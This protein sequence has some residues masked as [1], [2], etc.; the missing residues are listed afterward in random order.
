MSMAENVSI[1]IDFRDADRDD[2]LLERQTQTLF[3]ELQRLDE[4]AA[5]ERVADPNPP[6][7]NFSGGSWLP[8]KLVVQ[9][10]VQG[11]A[12]AMGVIS[13]QLGGRAIVIETKGPGD[14]RVEVKNSDD[15]EKATKLVQKLALG[16]P[17]DDGTPS[18]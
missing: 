12:K 6:E 16:E 2:V 10:L 8:G 13:K 3:R 4:I 5:V 14:Y 17:L 11:V 1:V 18:K 15:L 7:G 9:I